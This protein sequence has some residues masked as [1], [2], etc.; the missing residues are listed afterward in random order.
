[1]NER[2][3]ETRKEAEQIDLYSLLLDYLRVL[4]RMWL[5][6][7]LLAVAGGILFFIRDYMSWSPR[8]TASAVFTVN[9]SSD[10]QSSSGAGSFYASSTA[11][12]MEKT[13]PYILTSGV[14]SRRAAAE[15]GQDSI[16]GTIHASAEPNTNLFTMSVT[17]SDAQ[18]AYDTLQVVIKCYPEVAEVIVGRTSLQL[19]DES[20]VPVKPNNPR[21]SQESAKK[22]AVAGAGLGLAWTLFVTLSRRTV[23]RK[24]DIP[25]YINVKCLGEIPQV[26]LKKRSRKGKQV[27]NIT[28]EKINGDFLEAI[29]LIR[30]KIEYS[31]AKNHQKVVMVT[32]ALAGEGKSTVAVNLALSMAQNGKR[33]VLMDCDLRHPSD[34]EILRLPDGKGL[35]EV[36]KGEADI[37]EVL[38]DRKKLNFGKDMDFYFVPGG[39]AVADGSKLLDSRQM[40]IIFEALKKVADYIILDSAPIGILTDAGI[41]AQYADS[42]VCVVKKDYARADSIMEGMEELADGHVHVIGGILN[43]V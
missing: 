24:N 34:R 25:R 33:V 11:E 9:I 3:D 13:F 21:N 12:Q 6:V 22:G 30:N 41:L 4:S 15:M 26:T 32:S 29:R 19:L 28:D 7:V 2:N 35:Y 8:Y 42:A 10:T 23:R 36:L 5:W 1:M 14:L 37:Q 18:R 20:G 31:A 40:K 17:D 43:G 38:M 27:L 16:S 39:K